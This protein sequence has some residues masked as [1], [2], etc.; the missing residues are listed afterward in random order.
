[1][2][3]TGLPENWD[4]IVDTTPEA[5]FC[6]A[7]AVRDVWRLIVHTGVARTAREFLAKR[8]DDTELVKSRW[9]RLRRKTYP[10]PLSTVT[11]WHAMYK[12][13]GELLGTLLC[14]FYR[15]L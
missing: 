12:F 7:V 8:T 11:N 1:M 6:V 4:M 15:L 3:V 5:R 10:L 2:V 14:Q 13:T 9:R